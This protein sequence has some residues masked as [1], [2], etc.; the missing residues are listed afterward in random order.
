MKI[1]KSSVP[2]GSSKEKRIKVV[3]ERP[4][5]LTRRSKPETNDCLRVLSGVLWADLP[6]WLKL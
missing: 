5:I 2:K 1:I 6:H 3:K 4:R